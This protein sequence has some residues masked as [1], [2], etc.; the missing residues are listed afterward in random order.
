MNILKRELAPITDEAWKLIEE[1]A[2]STLLTHLSCRRFLDVE[3]PKGWGYAAHETGRLEVPLEQD[4]YAVCYGVHKVQ[5]VTETRIHFD[6]NIRE[7]D[8]AVRGAADIDLDPL[9]KAAEEI[10][11][12][13][14]VAVYN[15]FEKGSIQGLKALTESNTVNLGGKGGE[16]ILEAVSLAR[17]KMLANS[18]EGPYA[19]VASTELWAS[20]DAKSTGY[21]LRDRIVKLIGGKIVYNPSVPESYLVSLR[22]GDM[23][24]R[25]GEDFS[26][27]Y[28]AHTTGTVTLFIAESFTFTVAEPLA[29][30]R[31]V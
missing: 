21:P 20:L 10:A 13:E 11:L 29:A 27:G 22:G 23:T 3:G 16:D 14:E 17:A 7:L 9:T 4:K 8:N 25:L 18:I 15:G 24:I 12:F 6:L 1:Q 28:S 30:L 31:F 5:P 26:I 2:R 19:L